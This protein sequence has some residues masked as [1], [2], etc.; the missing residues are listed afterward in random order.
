LSSVYRIYRQSRNMASWNERHEI[1]LKVE[2]WAR[3]IRRP[4][5]SFTASGLGSPQRR[6][7]SETSY[8]QVRA[9]DGESTTSAPQQT[10]CHDE[11]VTQNG[12]DDVDRD[13][14][15]YIDRQN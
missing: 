2:K 4:N 6:A 8:F 13:R 11:I 10:P 15:H 5:A 3:L 7:T 14:D 9:S 1:E 12:N